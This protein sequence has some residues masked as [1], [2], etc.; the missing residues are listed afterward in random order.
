VRHVGKQFTEVYLV[1]LVCSWK[2]LKVVVP[3]TAMKCFQT[4]HHFVI[5]SSRS[6]YSGCRQEILLYEEVC[7]LFCFHLIIHYTFFIIYSIIQSYIVYLFIVKFFF[8]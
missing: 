3:I 4:R 2:R 8:L 7:F 6:K 1:F 5:T